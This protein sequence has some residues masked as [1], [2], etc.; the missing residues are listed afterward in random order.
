MIISIIGW[1]FGGHMSQGAA[2]PAAT[3]V[4]HIGSPASTPR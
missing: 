2:T 4:R 1:S 3:A